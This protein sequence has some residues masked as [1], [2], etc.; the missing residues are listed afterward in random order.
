MLQR[1]SSFS[2]KETTSNSN[3]GPQLSPSLVKSSQ[4]CSTDNLSDI[5]DSELLL[6]DDAGLTC[7]HHACNGASGDA[8]S[9]LFIE[10]VLKIAQRAHGT[11]AV[12]A[13]LNART[14][15]G[16]TV[17]HFACNKGLEK[18]AKLLA[19]QP[20][21]DPAVVD[22]AGRSA[23]HFALIAGHDGI[24]EWILF[25]LK[26]AESGGATRPSED[27]TQAAHFASLGGHVRALELLN[28]AG[29]FES[30]LPLTTK[31]GLSC[32]HM[33]SMK[34]HLEASQYLSSLPYASSMGLDVK[35][36]DSKN[37]TPLHMAVVGGHDTLV[38]WLLEQGANPKA[39]D[40][41]G[42]TALLL[43]QA[44]SRGS[45]G[46]SERIK[47]Y[48]AN[49]VAVP[50]APAS[51]PSL[52]TDSEYNDL[53]GYKTQV[54][55]AD[56]ILDNNV[57]S[58]PLPSASLPLASLPTRLYVKF[59]PPSFLPGA[60][61]T[62][63]YQLQV[64]QSSS[65]STWGLTSAWKDV[66][67]L[68][69][70]LT[71]A[72]SASA[73]STLFSTSTTP[74]SSID[75][76]ADAISPSTDAL[77]SPVLGTPVIEKAE[78]FSATTTT[79]SACIT[80]LSPATAYVVRVRA[81]N[82]HGFSTW[83]PSSKDMSTTAA[84]VSSQA[85]ETT[86][87]VDVNVTL[88]RKDD[89]SFSATV[90]AKD[91]STIFGDIKTVSTPSVE[92]PAIV[93]KTPTLSQ[94]IIEYAMSGNLS[95][96]ES[97]AAQQEHLFGS[98]VPEG[99]SDVYGVDESQRSV[100]HH[101]ASAGQLDVVKWFLRKV[102]K[103]SLFSVNGEN[104]DD[105]ISSSVIDAKERLALA[106]PFL[107]AVVGGHLP[108]V[109]YLASRG[110]S[111]DIRD[112]S[113][114]SALHYAVLKRKPLVLRWL[115]EAG[116]DVN[117]RTDKGGGVKELLDHQLGMNPPLDDE[118]VL[119]YMLTCVGNSDNLPNAPPP[120]TLL[121]SG[122]SSLILQIT[123][124][125][126]KNWTPGSSIPFAYEIQYAQKRTL[127]LFWST[128]C[129]TV[130]TGT[131]IFSD[132]YLRPSAATT[133]S[134]ASS[135]TSATSSAAATTS[136]TAITSSP[137]TGFSRPVPIQISGLSSDSKYTFQIRARNAR[138]WGPWSPKS[139]DFS[140]RAAN[141]KSNSI[142]ADLLDAC[143]ATQTAANAIASLGHPNSNNSFAGS[144]RTLLSLASNNV[145]HTASIL[146]T[147]TQKAVAAAPLIAPSLL[148]DDIISVGN[149]A[150]EKEDREQ[151]EKAAV[152]TAVDA[153]LKRGAAEAIQAS[154]AASIAQSKLLGQELQSMYN[155][156]TLG[157]ASS[158]ETAASR[159][160]EG[161]SLA[162]LA[163]A[164]GDQGM[165]V[166]YAL[167][168]VNAA[169]LLAKDAAGLTPLHYACAVGAKGVAAW[170]F[171]QPGG[172]I[173]SV[174]K[175]ILQRIPL[176]LVPT[177]SGENDWKFLL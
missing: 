133:T 71:G 35:A 21:F 63:E 18:T 173:S 153:A 11:L 144:G 168:K 22:S 171:S 15:K 37:R 121:D 100:L 113:G 148:D 128:S 174:T 106:T 53:L 24:S 111:I 16:A 152:A 91:D 60:F 158:I 75:P 54:M 139:A 172:E 127:G 31:D 83:S 146:S 177:E 101:A 157:D 41:D 29:V 56:G 33:S 123:S 65:K 73:L 74:P 159:D 66:Q 79:T 1:Q 176:D 122:R 105:I 23:L 45:G 57:T 95:G 9:V 136:A 78:T 8:L 112:A 115:C 135:T 129:D 44:L 49:N 151:A 39:A 13:L 77:L 55:D 19:S 6:A 154:R 89:V 114:L 64:M 147:K 86:S 46:S 50:Q 161:R 156:L 32:L 59:D 104:E 51:G 80:G 97:A 169:M 142:S 160:E 125:P 99:S 108:V 42:K 87:P 36:V 137:A 167:K 34:G 68:S 98:T 119:S 110:A 102:S 109:K 40:A 61:R 38:K 27:G 155:S 94:E 138:G 4:T 20:G 3:S 116:A 145:K 84:A 47:E 52:L 43:A 93:W 30:L 58:S 107:L 175:D 162:H 150:R 132:D 131:D 28:R 92:L 12:V 5:E 17:F 130:P 96:V 62:V 72:T 14:K 118:K 48:L 90:A 81:K 140:T 70:P 69:G 67:L 85:S 143:N 10:R 163:A 7:L 164:A 82:V 126:F 26:Q 103:S 170:L 166:L 141:D 134:A 117:V 88:Q 2:A 120:A 165:F 149:A 76:F 25:D 124:H